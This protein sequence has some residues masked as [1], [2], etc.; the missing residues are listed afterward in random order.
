[1]SIVTL[2]SAREFSKKMDAFVGRVIFRSRVESHQNVICPLSW[3]RRVEEVSGG[4]FLV[5][6]SLLASRINEGGRTLSESRVPVVHQ[7]KCLK[8]SIKKNFSC[9]ISFY[10]GGLVMALR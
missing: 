2:L 8:I 3:K 4:D 10:S 5:L 7:L 9:I 6:T 1:M